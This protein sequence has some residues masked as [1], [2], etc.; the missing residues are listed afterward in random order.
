M[1]LALTVLVCIAALAAAVWLGAR[2]VRPGPAGERTGG[3][4]TLLLAAGAGLALF[5][6]LSLLGRRKRA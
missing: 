1:T 4:G 3:P 6:L 5:F 2:L